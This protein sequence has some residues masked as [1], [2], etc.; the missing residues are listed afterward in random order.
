MTS[1]KSGFEE[2][3]HT[4]DWAVRVWADSLPGLFVETAR[5]M[6]SLAGV[7]PASSVEVTRTFEIKGEDMETLLIG[8]LSELIYSAE[9]EKMFFDEFEI[10]MDKS[11]LNVRMT[12]MPIGG[13]AKAIKAATYHDLHIIKTEEGYQVVIVF[14]V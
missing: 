13:M 11:G 5:A 8:F 3:P 9:Q 12:G 2:I 14:D 4:A 6:N 1:S 10:Q 7:V